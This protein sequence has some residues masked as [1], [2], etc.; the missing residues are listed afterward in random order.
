M[1][2]ETLTLKMIDDCIWCKEMALGIADNR[3]LSF[4]KDAAKKA[5]DFNVLV[6]HLFPVRGRHFLIVLTGPS[7][8]KKGCHHHGWGKVF[9]H[10]LSKLYLRSIHQGPGTLSLRS[11]AWEQVI[12]VAW[13]PWTGRC[14]VLRHVLLQQQAFL[15]DWQ[16]DQED[17]KSH[18]L[19]LQWFSQSKGFAPSVCVGCFA[20]FN[21]QL[22]QCALVWSC[23]GG[24]P[25]CF[26]TLCCE[27]AISSVWALIQTVQETSPC[28]KSIATW[29]EFVMYHVFV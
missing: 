29:T 4:Q 12:E 16:D 6:V 23:V 15:K 19:H 14:L 26:C 3:T 28:E 22:I 10:I 27:G 18:Y 1:S 8:N 9:Q 17:S 2:S 5:L 13:L 24:N 20:V 7:S 25:W 11:M 21:F